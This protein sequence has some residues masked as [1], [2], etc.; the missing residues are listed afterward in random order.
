MAF[1]FVQTADWQLGK[2]FSSIGGDAGA[3]L[4]D[5]RI[6]TV[7][8]IG[9]L[10]AERRVDAVLVAGDV[11]DANTV[12]E[13][14][15]IQALDALGEF[16]G[17]WVFIPGNHDP[18]LAD[19]VWTRLVSRNPPENVHVLVEPQ[20]PLYLRD[21]TVAILPAVL[22]RRHEA[23]DITAWFDTAETPAGAVRI[24]LAHGSVAE[25]L[26]SPS[27]APNPISAER[28]EAARLDY[29]AL[30][31]W[32][33][34]RR[35]NERTWY[36]GTPESDRFT[37]SDPGNVLLVSID[38]PSQIPNIETVKVGTFIWLS[39]RADLH[40]SADIA[41][42]DERIASLTPIPDTYLLSLTISGALDLARRTELGAIIEKWGA[43]LRALRIDEQGLV[44][45]PSDDDLDRI[46]RSGFVREAMER[47]RAR[48]RDNSDMEQAVAQAALIR[49]YEEHVREGG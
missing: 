4:R 38:G 3:A 37:S 33:G 36:A 28:A 44:A 8:A 14:T 32:H 45:E 41:A 15:L 34:T 43:L 16:A 11:F 7:R 10:A 5:Q 13:G 20:K 6:K 48:A 27:E 40:S 42:L 24:G 2:Q 47:L 49:L 19:S 39:E 30:G 21:G 25:Y 31:D 9:R 18:A 1:R 29:L 46:D 23:D 26:P 35:I 17:D 22:Q 12:A